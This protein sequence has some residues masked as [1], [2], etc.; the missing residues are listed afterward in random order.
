MSTARVARRRLSIRLSVLL[1]LVLPVAVYLGWLTNRARRQRE[2]IGIVRSMGG[3]VTFDYERSA[4]GS[5]PKLEPPGP[6]WLRRWVGDEY[7]QQI[8][9]ISVFSSGSKSLSA[10]QR[11]QGRYDAR[12]LR[13]IAAQK[14]LNVLRIRVDGSRVTDAGLAALAGLSELESLQIQSAE[15][16]TDEGLQAL[17]GLSKLQ[18]LLLCDAHQITDAGLKHLSGLPKLERL[19]VTESQIG[20][21]WYEQL[22]P[23]PSLVE[24][25]FGRSLGCDTVT[26]SGSRISD[27]GLVGLNQY[28]QL[29]SLVLDSPNLS[30]GAFVHLKDLS[31]LRTLWLTGTQ[32]TGRGLAGLRGLSRLAALSLEGD[33]LADE[34]VSEL[35]EL[36]SLRQVRLAGPKLTDASVARVSCLPAL[37]FLRLDGPK[38]TD[39][40]LVCLSHSTSLRTLKLDNGGS[41]SDK[42]LDAIC[43]LP[44]LGDL[45][46]ALWRNGRRASGP[47]C[48]ISDRGLQT[49]KGFPAL[50]SVTLR[51]SRISRRAI[52]ALA[53]ARPGLLVDIK[54]A[55]EAR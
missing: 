11:A 15:L 32:M 43:G 37:T 31:Q 44:K 46:F 29:Q 42:A 17:R 7:F 22:G 24:L 48:Q 14:H 3:V 40:G 52:D 39:D 2:L 5:R 9:E 34:G 8:T 47:T 30:D 12:L 45:E 19:C 23:S 1:A 6:R 28:P 36:K 26:H 25:Y 41:F 16:L 10:A 13:L 53:K 54:T 21:H 18:L 33:S 51:S 50:N 49:I 35:A 4:P 55:D 38:F 20:D 27:R